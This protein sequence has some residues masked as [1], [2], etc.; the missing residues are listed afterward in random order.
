MLFRSA[1]LARCPADFDSSTYV[2][3]DDYD[4]FVAAFADGSPDADFDSNSFVNGDDFDAFSSAFER[5][6]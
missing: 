2:N 1:A 6:C 5:G 3:G 4:A